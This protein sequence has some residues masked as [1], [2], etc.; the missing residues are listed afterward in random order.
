LF[1]AAL[2]TRAVPVMA[3]SR[4]WQ[5]STKSMTTNKICTM[6]RAWGGGAYHW[7]FK[8]PFLTRM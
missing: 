8:R 6:Y 4:I 3:N 1:R 7:I 2:P 5:Q